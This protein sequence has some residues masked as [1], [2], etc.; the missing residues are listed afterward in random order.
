MTKLSKILIPLLLASAFFF[1]GCQVSL[2]D[3]DKLE[4]LNK[5][6]EATKLYWEIVK[7]D[8]ASYSL[9]TKQ[10]AQ[11]RILRLK[12]QVIVPEFQQE[13]ISNKDSASKLLVCDL[14]LAYNSTPDYRCIVLAGIAEKNNLENKKYYASSLAELQ[15]EE[16]TTMMINL[17]SDSVQ[18]YDSEIKEKKDKGIT[19]NLSS[20]YLLNYYQLLALYNLPRTQS[21]LTSLIQSKKIIDRP[22][23]I[24]AFQLIDDS[25]IIEPL[26]SITKSTSPNENKLITDIFL[27]F[28]EPKTFS[29]LIG[30]AVLNNDNEAKIMKYLESNLSTENLKYFAS[31]FVDYNYQLTENAVILAKSLIKRIPSKESVS[32]LCALLQLKDVAK[33][34]TSYAEVQDIL[35]F[36][37]KNMTKENLPD[38]LY[39]L[40]KNLTI[41][42]T[43]DFYALDELFQQNVNIIN[44]FYDDNEYLR[45][46][47]LELKTLASVY[48]AKQNISFSV[49]KA[50]ASEE[51]KTVKLLL[52]DILTQTGTISNNQP[53][54]KLLTNVKFFASKIEDIELKKMLTSLIKSSQFEKYISNDDIFNTISIPEKQTP[55]VNIDTIKTTDE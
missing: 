36:I 3:G 25:K 30:Q 6:T 23:L 9:E 44:K 15:S 11:K 45:F 52:E 18:K 8:S 16:I 38:L 5:P 33:N 14:I 54:S 1:V 21:F 24:K 48:K 49:Q 19:N 34:E 22:S 4:K 35:A 32:A 43:S 53:A 26:L 55:S 2:D 41:R 7:G 28:N 50:R 12:D 51:L 13:I 27:K 29:F 37:N 17:Y 46:F 42:S 40:E 31:T 10:E 39:A 47:M 20:D